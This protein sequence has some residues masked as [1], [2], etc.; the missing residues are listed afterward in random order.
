MLDIAVAYHRY[1][2]LGDE[3]LT[4]L[5][6]GLETRNEAFCTLDP[7]VQAFEVADRMVIENREAQ[8]KEKITIRGED[9]GL[10]EARIALARGAWVSELGLVLRTER[11]EFRFTLK[12]ENLNL[13]GLKTTPA[14]SFSSEEDA[15]ARFLERMDYLKN[16]FEFI[17]KIFSLFLSERLSP[18]WQGS[19]LAAMRQWLSSERRKRR[20]L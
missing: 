9:P 7:E 5:W 17:D 4:W 13:C 6:H 20:S 12:A 16:L 14:S 3:F 10:E 19:H 15:E 18:Q 8:K 2:F 11:Q 1:R